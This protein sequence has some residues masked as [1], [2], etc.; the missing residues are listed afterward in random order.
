MN[1]N[2]SARAL[3]RLLLLL[4]VNSRRNVIYTLGY[5]WQDGRIFTFAE[6]K[7]VAIDSGAIDT[8]STTFGMS[9][10]QTSLTRQG[11]AF[12][13]SRTT[14]NALDLGFFRLE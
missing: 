14:S 1:G 2:I 5:A 4:V 12:N 6:L 10:A 8:N 7:L 9:Q 13:K 3:N 11:G